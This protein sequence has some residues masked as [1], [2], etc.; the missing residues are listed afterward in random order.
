MVDPD[1]YFILFEIIKLTNLPIS[2]GSPIFFVG[3]VFSNTFKFLTR[4][5]TL[6]VLMVQVLN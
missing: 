3:N 5:L 1:K 2:F 4:A 6:P